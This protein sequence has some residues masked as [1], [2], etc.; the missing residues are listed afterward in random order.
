[1]EGGGGGGG[2]GRGREGASL[3]FSYLAGISS[4]S[5]LFFFTQNNKEGG[6]GGGKRNWSPSPGSATDGV[7]ARS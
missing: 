2:G 4:F 3:V 7:V 1:M 5:H 6:R